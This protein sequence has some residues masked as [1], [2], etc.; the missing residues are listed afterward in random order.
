MLRLFRLRVCQLSKGATPC[1]T[2]RL[3]SPTAFEVTSKRR[4][5]FPSQ[6]QVKRG[7]QL[8]HGDKELTEKLGRNDLCLCGVRTGGFKC[9]C[10]GSGCYDGSIR[11]FYF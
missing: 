4:K 8:V 3:E 2:K 7:E 5:G 9:C 10:L 6:T 11:N 1:E